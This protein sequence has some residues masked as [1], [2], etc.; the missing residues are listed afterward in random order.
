MFNY[1]NKA[2]VKV[3]AKKGSSHSHIVLESVDNFSPHHPE[4]IW[5]RSF[6]EIYS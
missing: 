4:H 1:A 2:V 3:E 5:T 6:I